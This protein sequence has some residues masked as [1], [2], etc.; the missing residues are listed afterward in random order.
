MESSM[1]VMSGSG[2]AYDRVLAGTPTTVQRAGAS[3][4][5]TAPAPTT[6]LL[7]DCGSREHDRTD[8]NMRER[9]DTHTAAEDDAGRDVNVGI[10]FTVM[11]DYGSGVDNAVLTDHRTGINDYSRHYNGPPPDGRRRSDHS[12]WMNEEFRKESGITRAAE[13][14]GAGAVI[15]YGDDEGGAEKTGQLSRSSDERTIT[16]CE[17]DCRGRVVEK[18][19]SLER[20]HAARDIENDLAVPSGTPDQ[21]ESTHAL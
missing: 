7:A 17:T 8:S 5:T 12:S 15:S 2:Y 19:D 16:K 13:A 21:Q 6:R 11:L 3:L 10:D 14:V 1:R 18:H 4:R 9:P 20:S